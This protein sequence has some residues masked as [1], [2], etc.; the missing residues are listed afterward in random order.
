VLYAGAI[1]EVIKA[2]RPGRVAVAFSGRSTDVFAHLG[3]PAEVHPLLLPRRALL[4]KDLVVDF[5]TDIPP[6][7]HAGL[8]MVAIDT[9]ILEHLGLPASYRWPHLRAP[10]AIRRIGIFPQASSSVRTLPP[11]LSAFLVS[12]LGARGFAVEVMVEP[13]FRQG[14]LYGEALSAMLGAAAPIVDHL[15]TV[16]QLLGF[17]RDIDYGIFCDSGPAHMAK[18]F[19]LP[20]LGIYTTV[21]ADVVQGHFDNLARWS[22]DYAGNWCRAPCGLVKLMKT[23]D[24]DRYGC[25]DSLR[26]QRADLVLPF[27]VPDAD[28]ERFLL[29]EPVGCVASLIRDKDA[30]L[31]RLLDHLAAVSKGVETQ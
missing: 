31:R 24:G 10:R 28:I 3:T 19:A 7:R 20:G 4:D 14:R 6:L 1:R 18:M 9:L 21:A 25:M 16:E 8:E 17:V 29:A 2:Y 13:R 30:I 26:C 22:A 12:E 23:A 11:A 27:R 5:E 15:A